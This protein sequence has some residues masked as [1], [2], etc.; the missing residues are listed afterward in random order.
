VKIRNGFVSNSSS[1]SFL[2]A[3]KTQPTSV[4][5]LREMLFGELVHI[6]QYGDPISTQE[7]AEVVWRDMQRQERPP[8]RDEIEDNMG[9]KAYSQVYEENDGWRVRSKKT[10]EEQELQ[11][12]ED[13][14]RCSVLAEQ[15]ADE[16]LQQAEGGR[17]YAFSYS[18]NDGNLESTL[19]H[20]G[21]FDK[22]PHVTISNH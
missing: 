21:I 7:A 5:H 20:Y 19:E 22:L 1:S 11:H 13:T 6:A 12:A 8:T 10:R 4:E 3:F 17:I 18:D 14:R 16:F 2:V 9:T 15:M